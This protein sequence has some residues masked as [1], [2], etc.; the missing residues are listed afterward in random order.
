MRESRINFNGF[1]TYV[2]HRC[3]ATDPCEILTNKMVSIDGDPRWFLCDIHRSTF[4]V[5]R[6]TGLKVESIA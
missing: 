3:E 6:L 2:W 1:T 4:E 5:E